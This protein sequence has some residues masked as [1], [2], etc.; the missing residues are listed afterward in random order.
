[1]MARAERCFET[2]LSLNPSDAPAH[3]NLAMVMERT[4]RPAEAVFRYRRFLEVANV[5]HR[6]AIPVV[7]DR[8]E[9]ILRELHARPA[10]EP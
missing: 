8:I 4:G 9:R 3:Y 10:R 7:R 1:M 2:V 6:E 5:D